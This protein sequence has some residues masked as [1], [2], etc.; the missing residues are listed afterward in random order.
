MNPLGGKGGRLT[1]AQNLSFT[2]AGSQAWADRV[3]TMSANRSR[4]AVLA[5]VLLSGASLGACVSPDMGGRTSGIGPRYPVRPPSTAEAQKPAPGKPSNQ[6][7]GASASASPSRQGTLK[8]GKPYQING[9]W[10]TPSEDPDYDETG[11]ASWYGEAFN[12]KAT[13][14]GEPFD[15]Y[16]PSAAHKTLPLQSMV[17]VTNLDNGRVIKVRIN[18]RGPFVDGRIIDLSRGA[19]EQLGMLRAGVAHVRVRY[20]G[21]AGARP[22]PPVIYAANRNPPAAAAPPPPR[23]A[24]P[25]PAPAPIRAAELIIETAALAPPPVIS[26]PV[27]STPVIE[28]PR[29]VAASYEV[30]AGAFSSRVNA[31]RVQRQLAEAGEVTIRTQQR[32][33]GPLY[34]VVVCSLPDEDAAWT[35][36]ERV[37][38]LGFPDARVIRPF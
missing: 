15:M 34:R 17:E 32:D 21:P 5:L 13:A 18:D 29:I 30:Q 16:A 7:P 6:R 10:Y 9:V 1:E 28:A 20:I 2:M 36:R 37:A 38:L 3:M 35:V 11:L 33:S 24:K 23:Y 4:P 8:V 19:A 26:A 12:M 31:E 22:E 27:I 25:D 14:S